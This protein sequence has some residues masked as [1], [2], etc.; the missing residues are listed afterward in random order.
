M[1]L[2]SNLGANQLTEASVVA[3]SASSFTR[4]SFEA[5]QAIKPSHHASTRDSKKR[6]STIQR[7]L[8][9]KPS[10]DDKSPNASNNAHLHDSQRMHSPHHTALHYGSHESDEAQKLAGLSRAVL[11]QIVRHEWKGK[12]HAREEEDEAEMNQI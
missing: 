3:Q 9:L 1:C 7:T 6:R 10:Q 2:L 8:R 5:A 12:L 4:S 11:E